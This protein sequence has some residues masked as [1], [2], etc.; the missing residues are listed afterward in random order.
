MNNFEQ[1]FSQNNYDYEEEDQEEGDNENEMYG[2][3]YG[4][5]EYDDDGILITEELL[6]KIIKL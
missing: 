1:D 3:N 4:E 6:I 2:Q 5:E